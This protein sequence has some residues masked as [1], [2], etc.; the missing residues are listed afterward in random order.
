LRRHHHHHQPAGRHRIINISG[1]QDGAHTYSG[2]NGNSQALWYQPFNTLGSLLAWTFPPGAYNFR[3]VDPAG[4]QR[5]FPA[6][7][8]AQTNQIYTAW[9]YNSPWIENYMAFD[10]AAAT[11]T[12]LPQLFDGAP[13]PTGFGDPQSAYNDTVSNG[14]FDEI[15]TGP[16]G[17]AGTNFSYAYTFT[18]TETLI[19]IVPDYDLSDNAGGVSVVVSP[20]A[21][22][23]VKTGAGAVTL[24]WATNAPG[25]F[26]S[27]T[28]NLLLT[29]WSD[30]TNAPITANT[31]Y[32]VTLPLDPSSNRFFRLHD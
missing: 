28:T 20:A 2:V 14:Y 23:S 12:S 31:N 25:F 3:V 13:D 27:Q 1:T 9:T 21:V 18:N 26:L 29:S 15:R 6:L 7:T 5:L 22:L 17:R 19:F 24:Q 16:L 30:V 4:A 32:S 8:A 10:S 11:D